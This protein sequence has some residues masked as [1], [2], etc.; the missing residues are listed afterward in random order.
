MRTIRFRLGLL[1]FGSLAIALVAALG[2]VYAVHVTDRTVDRALDAQ[3]RLDLLTELSGRIQE[4]GLIAIAAVD[5]PTSSGARLGEAEAGVKH[6]DRQLRAG[7][8]QGDP[9]RR[10]AGRCQRH[11]RACPGRWSR[12]AP[13]FACWSSRSGR[14]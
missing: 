5:D 3:R 7:D 8:R 12:F 6:R 13:A 10:P 9:R 11:G 4:F 14:R 1:V 2:V